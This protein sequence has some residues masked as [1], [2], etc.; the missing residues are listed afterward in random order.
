MQLMALPHTPARGGVRFIFLLKHWRCI[1]TCS[2]LPCWWYSTQIMYLA[3][4]LRVK[5]FPDVKSKRTPPLAPVLVRSLGLPVRLLQT[6]QLTHFFYS[7]GDV[8]A[9][10][11]C[12]LLAAYLGKRLWGLSG[13]FLQ[14]WEHFQTI[15]KFMP[16]TK[17]VSFCVLFWSALHFSNALGNGVQVSLKKTHY[18][19][20]ISLSSPSPTW[21]QAQVC[22][23]LILPAVMVLLGCSRLL[24][25]LTLSR[26]PD[27]IS[28]VSA[29]P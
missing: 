8:L 1:L 26:R 14:L 29:V 18:F 9:F 22:Y 4:M 21:S 3:S 17:R 7:L 2:S 13:L 15:A 23:S 24:L 16:V 12:S 27:F 25:T 20:D 28:S 6:F 11:F 19:G 5:L 10:F